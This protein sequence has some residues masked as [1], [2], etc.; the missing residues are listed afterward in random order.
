MGVFGSRKKS[1]GAFEFRVSDAVEVPLRGYLLRLKLTGGD[2]GLGDLA[3]GKNITLR[4][5][6]GKE[7]VILI[8]DQ[9]LTQGVA[10]QSRLDRTREFDIVI[11]GNDAVVD[12]ELAQ[13][14]W[15]VVSAAND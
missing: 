15:T 7:R 8:K 4:S 1:G 14:G 5:P 12:G 3:P 11:E 6:S 2:P 13:I 9:S 10:S